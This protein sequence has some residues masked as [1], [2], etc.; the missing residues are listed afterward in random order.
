MKNNHVDFND[1]IN[2]LDIEKESFMDKVE[3]FIESHLWISIVI[4]IFIFIIGLLVIGSSAIVFLKELIFLIFKGF[5]FI[6]I[7]KIIIS[8]AIISFIVGTIAYIYEEQ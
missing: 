2:N 1:N 4:G 6:R 7:I 8:L 5:S 3:D